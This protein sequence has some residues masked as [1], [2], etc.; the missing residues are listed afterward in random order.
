MKNTY[1]V[2][3]SSRTPRPAALPDLMAEQGLNTIFKF[4]PK[5]PGKYKNARI[6]IFMGKK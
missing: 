6:G 1:P 5:L 2:I 4:L 3:R